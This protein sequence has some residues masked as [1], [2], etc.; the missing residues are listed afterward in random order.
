MP[1]S[2][3]LPMLQNMST[4]R[5]YSSCGST[6]ESFFFTYR[7]QEVRAEN[8]NIM[9]YFGF[10][11]SDFDERHCFLIERLL[12]LCGGGDRESSGSLDA[13]FDSGLGERL[14]AIAMQDKLVTWDNEG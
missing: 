7:D 5:A 14:R 11:V 8:V 9:P 13:E 1:I 4:H 3:V 6:S 2:I 10:S 12:F